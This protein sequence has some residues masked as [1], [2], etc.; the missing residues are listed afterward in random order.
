LAERWGREELRQLLADAR[1]AIRHPDFG[2][3]VVESSPAPAPPES[4][5]CQTPAPENLGPR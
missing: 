3:T 4:G 1:R 2:P 5:A